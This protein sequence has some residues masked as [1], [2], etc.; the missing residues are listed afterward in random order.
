MFKFF[1]IRESGPTDLT[2]DEKNPVDYLYRTVNHEE[3]KTTLENRE[4][5]DKKGETNKERAR[6]KHK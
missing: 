2:C 5:F 1:I 3:L 6:K 4:Q